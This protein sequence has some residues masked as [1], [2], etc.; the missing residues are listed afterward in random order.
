[1]NAVYLT[2]GSPRSIKIGNR[3]IKFKQAAPKK[4]SA[5]GELSGMAILALQALGKDNLDKKREEHLVNLLKKEDVAKL[6]H[7]IKL[8]PDWIARVLKKALNND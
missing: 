8:A 6:K 7:D 2:D 5:K 4:L 1:M 3:T